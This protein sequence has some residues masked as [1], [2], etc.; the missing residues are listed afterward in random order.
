MQLLHLCHPSNGSKSCKESLSTAGWLQR[1]IQH[2]R[3][4]G[5]HFRTLIPSVWECLHH[6]WYNRIYAS[7]K[8]TEVDLCT[9]VDKPPR[10]TAEWK[11]MFLNDSI[12]YNVSFMWAKIFV[13][14]RVQWPAPRTVQVQSTYL[15]STECMNLRTI[16]YLEVWAQ[17]WWEIQE[18][19]FNASL[20]EY[21][22]CLMKV[23]VP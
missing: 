21:W 1:N 2:T 8:M 3:L 14:F 9:K 5:P 17:W 11:K 13:L 4:L 19:N 10:H 7:F 16:Y 20:L 22:T 23:K 12:Y 18:G 6:L 15:T